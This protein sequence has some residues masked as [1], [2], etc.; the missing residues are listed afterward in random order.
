M[1]CATTGRQLLR[2]WSAPDWPSTQGVIERHVMDASW[3]QGSSTVYIT[4]YPAYL[5]AVNGQLYRGSGRDLS[6]NGFFGAPSFSNLEREKAALTLADL[7]PGQRVTVF[8]NPENHGDA[9]LDREPSQ[10]WVREGLALVFAMVVATVCVLGA[11]APGPV[12]G[13]IVAVLTVLFCWYCWYGDPRIAYDGNADPIPEP[14][15]LVE[16]FQ[17][18]S[19]GPAPV[20]NSTSPAQRPTAT[21]TPALSR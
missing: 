11:F 3:E 14:P 7:P 15:S 16:T 19:P 2:I 10:R 8:Y 13:V 21:P 20:P 18:D 5:Y 1:V 17:P 4:P 6:D 9:V 12:D